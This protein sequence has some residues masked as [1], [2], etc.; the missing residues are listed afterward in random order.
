MVGEVWNAGVGTV[1]LGTGVPALQ[2]IHGL[3]IEG[4][5]RFEELSRGPERRYSL[6]TEGRQMAEG[7]R[8][9]GGRR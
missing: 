3:E 6:T 2:A 9:G 4:L 1:T 8:K 7:T 5:I